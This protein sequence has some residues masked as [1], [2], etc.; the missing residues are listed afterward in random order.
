MQNIVHRECGCYS[1]LCVIFQLFFNLSSSLN[2]E[3]IRRSMLLVWSQSSW[4]SLKKLNQQNVTA[5]KWNPTYSPFPAAR[6]AV[7]LTNGGNS[8]W[9]GLG[10]I[11]WT[12]LPFETWPSEEQ[13]GCWL[14]VFMWVGDEYVQIRVCKTGSRP[15]FWPGLHVLETVEYGNDR[16]FLLP[17][18]VFLKPV[19][20][21]FL[22]EHFY[23]HLN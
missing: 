6:G 19:S 21:A 16:F 5:S 7:F 8:Q 11:D 2:I 13:L 4:K 17:F 3:C 22:F 12:L 9:L 14:L 18:D 15:L 1:K 23:F 10:C 20:F